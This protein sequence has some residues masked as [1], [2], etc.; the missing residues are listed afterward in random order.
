MTVLSF[1]GLLHIVFSDISGL[2]WLVWLAPCAAQVC[3]RLVR[4]GLAVWLPLCM[5]LGLPTVGLLVKSSCEGCLISGISVAVGL[6][7]WV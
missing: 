3:V 7:L 4:V 6:V 1:W 5:V 2:S